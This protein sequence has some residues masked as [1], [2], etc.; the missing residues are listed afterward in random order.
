MKRLLSICLVAAIL[1]GLCDTVLAKKKK[2]GGGGGRR[3]PPA[4]PFQ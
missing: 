2:G 3:P 1:F 4:Q